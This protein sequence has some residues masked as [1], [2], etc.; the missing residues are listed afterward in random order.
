[1]GAV[2]RYKGAHRRTKDYSE[3]ECTT[4]QS[5][6]QV[7]TSPTQ[8]GLCAI[9]TAVLPLIRH[10]QQIPILLEVL[11]EVQPNSSQHDHVGRA[12]HLNEP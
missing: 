11:V 7:Q 4:K 2:Y 10:I 3:K 9:F 8:I 1:M 12:H 5:H 6:K